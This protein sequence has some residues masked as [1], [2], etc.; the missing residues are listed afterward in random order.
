MRRGPKTPGQALFMVLF[1][2]ALIGYSAWDADIH[3]A[4][5]RVHYPDQAEVHH[6][7]SSAERHDYDASK[8]A[9]PSVP[10]R[11]DIQQL[12]GWLPLAAAAGVG[13]GGLMVAGVGFTLLRGRDDDDAPVDEPAVFSL[14]DTDALD[15]FD[16]DQLR[17]LLARHDAAR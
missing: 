8:V 7:E 12:P 5:Q 17:D 4:S 13:F 14:D 11:D 16:D 2:T 10:P 15:A 1:S 3:N 6:H 9:H